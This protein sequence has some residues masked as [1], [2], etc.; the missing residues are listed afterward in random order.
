LIT[1]RCNDA[2]DVPWDHGRPARCLDRRTERAQL[3]TIGVAWTRSLSSE[4]F[5]Q[6]AS[7]PRS[8]GAGQ[9]FA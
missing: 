4:P 3:L 2:T 5:K 1:P 9:G 8:Q 7:R 6:R